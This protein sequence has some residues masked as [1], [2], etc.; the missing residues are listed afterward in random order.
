LIFP[1]FCLKIHSKKERFLRLDL[2][3]W[4]DFKQGLCTLQR[5]LLLAPPFFGL[6]YLHNHC[7][8][9]FFSPL[10]SLPPGHC[11]L[12]LLHFTLAKMSGTELHAYANCICSAHGW[13]L[14]RTLTG[15]P[16][17]FS[18]P[19]RSLLLCKLQLRLRQRSTG[20]DQCK[21]KDTW[22]VFS[23]LPPVFPLYV[24]CAI[25]TLTPTSMKM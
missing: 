3:N 16:C 10:T 22:L 17:L 15:C 12:H 11:H 14:F 7:C 8:C 25:G 20:L 1:R 9:P 24:A 5:V 4:Y 13:R 23:P 19:Q 18:P 21:S 6:L 2:R